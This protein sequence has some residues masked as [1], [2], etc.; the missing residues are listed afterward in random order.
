MDVIL[1]KSINRNVIIY[2]ISSTII[3]KMVKTKFKIVTISLPDV[4][5]QKL[6]S[7]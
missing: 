2:N 7:Y 5:K 1:F 6:I 3:T 4:Q